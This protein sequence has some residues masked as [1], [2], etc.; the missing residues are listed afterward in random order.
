MRY[1]K[2]LKHDEI[3][4]L[5]NKPKSTKRIKQLQQEINL[6]VHELIRL[7]E[8]ISANYGKFMLIE[9]KFLEECDIVLSTLN[10]SGKPKYADFFEGKVECLIID[11][12][13]QATETSTLV[14]FQCNPQKVLLVGDHKQLP[15]TVM[16]KNANKTKF[17]R[18]LF[19]RFI[20]LGYKPYLLDTQ[21]RMLPELREFPS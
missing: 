8:V 19:E 10:T 16:S 9:N 14:P 1:E 12:A 2:D 11:E 7:K 15:P 4:K 3:N 17:N 6:I 18:S 21:Y 5:F 13:G 20:D